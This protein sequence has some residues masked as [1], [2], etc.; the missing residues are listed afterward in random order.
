MNRRGLS[1][2]DGQERQGVFKAD[3]RVGLV[4]F[5]KEPM[6]GEEFLSC[7]AS[8]EGDP[9]FEAHKRH[10]TFDL[11]PGELAP[12]GNHQPDRLEGIILR[13]SHCIWGRPWFSRGPE[14]DHDSRNCVRKSQKIASKIIDKARGRPHYRTAQ[15]AVNHS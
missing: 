7:A 1:E 11:V 9:A 8:R 6:P 12:L 4:P 14:V 3:E 5:Q 13:Q 10:P 2:H 15:R